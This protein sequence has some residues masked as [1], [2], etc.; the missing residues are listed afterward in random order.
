MRTFAISIAL[1]L[2]TLASPSAGAQ[3]GSGEFCLKT[4]D[5]QAKCDYRSMAQCE[6]ARP[7]GSKDQCVEKLQL[8]GTTGTGGSSPSRG[9]PQGGKQMPP[10]APPQ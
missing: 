2:A 7:A 3:T 8:G 9:S 4:M 1:T 5:G 10:P 6:Q